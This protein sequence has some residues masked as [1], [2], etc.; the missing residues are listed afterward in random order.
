MSVTIT[1]PTCIYY[2]TIIRQSSVTNILSVTMT[3]SVTQSSPTRVSWSGTESCII[4]CAYTC[5]AFSMIPTWA[6]VR[7]VRILWTCV[8]WL[9]LVLSTTPLF[10][11]D[12]VYT[13]GS[14]GTFSVRAARIRWTCAAWLAFVLSTTSL[15]IF[16]IPGA[17]SLFFY[18]P[19]DC[20]VIGLLPKKD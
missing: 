11:L 20:V 14:C 9:A 6:S 1:P 17:E 4:F 5:G 18:H 16:D 15:F 8:A 19:R 13:C 3:P 7:A 2:S 10:F 12:F